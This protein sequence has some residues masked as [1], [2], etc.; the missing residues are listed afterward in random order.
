M[1]RGFKRVPPGKDAFGRL[2]LDAYEQFEEEKAPM[3]PE[4]VQVVERDDGMITVGLG[5]DFY[6]SEFRE[7]SPFERRVVR[8]ARGRVLD[9]GCGA[10]RI[11]RY[12]ADRGM[13]VMGIDT[14]PGAVEVSR[15]R[16]VE[17]RVAGIEDAGK[18]GRFDT[19][20]LMGH[21]IGLLQSRSKAVRFLRAMGRVST[22]SGRIL[23][24]SLDPKMTDSPEHLAYHER[25]RGK[26]R[27]PGQVRLRVRYRM[28]SSPWFDYMHLAL[29]ELEEIAGEAGWKIYRVFENNPHYGVV[30]EKA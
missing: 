24:S 26:G 17:A 12:L 20:L 16:G 11:A 9:I 15:A 14:S 23:G 10:G 7:W 27:M 18:L 19:F 2:L 28:M 1:T 3:T 22:N 4:L 13:E 8:F 29:A 30:L 6:F 21:N 5:A 25:N